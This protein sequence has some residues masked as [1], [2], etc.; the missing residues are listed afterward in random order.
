MLETSTW[1][2]AVPPPFEIGPKL[3]DTFRL[4]IEP[5]TAPSTAE[6]S[7]TIPT[8]MNLAENVPK[9]VD[10]VCCRGTKTLGE[11]ASKA[12]RRDKTSSVSR[13]GHLEALGPP[14][15]GIYLRRPSP[16]SGM[17]AQR[18]RPSLHSF[19][20]MLHPRLKFGSSSA[21]EGS[22]SAKSPAKF[23]KSGQPRKIGLQDHALL[24][25]RRQWRPPKRS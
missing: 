10:R 13:S 20:P 2:L 19:A 23:A 17:S 25:L 8:V 9:Q 3:S 21:A 22:L 5:N 4:G 14:R 6:S 18:A 7:E 1:R 11:S 12:W 24:L 15:Q 16:E